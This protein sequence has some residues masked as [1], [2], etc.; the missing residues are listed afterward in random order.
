MILDKD[1]LFEQGYLTFNLQDLDEE[2]FDD[3][4]SQ[5]S[6]D[7]LRKSI[8]H[9]RFDATIPSKALPYM[10]E[11]LIQKNFNLDE[12]NTQLNVHDKKLTKF[13]SNFQGEL[14]ELKKL[15]E[16]LSEYPWIKDGQQWYHGV[17]D[18]YDKT[19]KQELIGSLYNT[20]IK[21]L[22][23]DYIKNSENYS[24]DY[25]G[26]NNIIKGTDV[27]MYL[28][29]GYITPHE[30]GYDE[31]RLCVMLMYMNEDYDYGYGGEIIVNGE[32]TVEPKEGN[33]VILDFL[34]NNIE[35]EVLPIIK[36][37]FERFAFIKFFYE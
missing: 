20:T 34:H 30:D 9:F 12:Y 6:D 31:G 15:D 1:K 11:E 10:F 28:Q 25:N 35:H 26:P 21:K 2:L 36:N 17:L 23:K 14:S 37:G 27:T 8:N 4:Q 29:D 7:Y 18:L 33:I 32:L 22:Y 19:T 13:R 3:I 5:F 24:D 16:Y